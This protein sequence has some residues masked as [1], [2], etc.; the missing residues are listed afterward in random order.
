MPRQTFTTNAEPMETQKL[1]E[2]VQNF[3][4]VLAGWDE[5]RRNQFAHEVNITWCFHEFALEGVVLGELEIRS[6]LDDR[7]ISD[8]SLIPHYDDVVAFYKGMQQ[9]R[10]DSQK[11]RITVNMTYIKELHELITPPEDTKLLAY[12]KE[13]PLHRQYA[14]DFA[15]PEKIPYRMRKLGEWMQSP[16]Y[17][18]LTPIARAAALHNR[19]MAVFPWP[20][21]SGSL[22][23]LIM[24]IVLMHAGYPPAI[25]PHQERQ[26]YYDHILADINQDNEVH[27]VTMINDT[28]SLFMNSAVKRYSR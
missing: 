17:R 7:V 18:K 3:N 9:A 10:Q 12:R 21:N 1:D 19:I 27:M 4:K 6:A 2:D 16:G 14:H 15:P 24:N 11:K 20:K 23:R 25:I 22:A 8:S 13:M 28:I 5:H 26:I